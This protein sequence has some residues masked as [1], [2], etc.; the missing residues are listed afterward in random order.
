GILLMSRSD[1]DLTQM[2]D[3]PG[4]TK[5]ATGASLL[6]LFVEVLRLVLLILQPA[7]HIQL[8]PAATRCLHV[9]PHERRRPLAI[10][11]QR[12]LVQRPP[13]VPRFGAAGRVGVVQP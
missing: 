7:R 11:Q 8:G 1:T 4:L 12:R 9:L 13:E 6:W 10:D 2:A 3:A 5:A